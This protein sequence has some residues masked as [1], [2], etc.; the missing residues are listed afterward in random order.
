[1]SIR[2]KIIL[3]VLPLIFTTLLLTG[4]SSYF[5]ATNGITHIAKEFLGFK[6]TELE[7]YAASQ[8]SL[9]VENNFTERPDYVIATKKAV[10]D[11]ARGIIEVALHEKVKL[12]ISRTRIEPPFNSEWPN[13]VPSEQLLRKRYYPEDFFKGKTQDRGFLDVWSSVMHNFGTMGDFGNYV[14]KHIYPL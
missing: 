9:L 3:I 4:I 6:A 13:E 11:Y 8:W 10:E 1:M 2:L 14:L 5:S 7:K 12:R